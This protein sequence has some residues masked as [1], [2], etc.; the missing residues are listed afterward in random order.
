MRDQTLLCI[1]CGVCSG[2]T[3]ALLGVEGQASD[4]LDLLNVDGLETGPV[5]AASDIVPVPLDGSTEHV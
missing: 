4:L 3:Q 1:G 2:E 5:F